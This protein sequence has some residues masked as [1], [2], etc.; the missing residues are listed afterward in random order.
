MRVRQRGFTLIELMVVAILV[1]ILA[2]IAL[3]A[4]QNQVRKGNR[5]AAQQFMA[6]V[7]IKEQQYLLDTRGYVSA[8][9]ATFSSA[10]NLTIPQKVSSQYTISVDPTAANTCGSTGTAGG[11]GSSAFPANLPKFVITAAPSAGSPQANDGTNGGRLCMDSSGNK[12]PSDKW[13]L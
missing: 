1:G 2:A 7:A 8:T 13:S 11:A 10:L 3:P 5:S 4:Y 9:N 6:D 12:T